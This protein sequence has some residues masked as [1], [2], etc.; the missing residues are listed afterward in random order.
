[1]V[2]EG[3]FTEGNGTL[4]GYDENEHITR[5]VYY[6]KNVI[7]KEEIYAPDGQKIEKTLFHHNGRVTDIQLNNN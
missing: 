1:M 6:E 7:I 3:I 2:G 4:T 5:K